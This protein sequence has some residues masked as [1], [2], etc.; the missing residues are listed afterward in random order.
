MPVVRVNNIDV[1]YVLERPAASDAELVVLVNGLAD[2]LQTWDY[3]VGDLL[4]AGYTVLRYDNRGIGLSSR[5]AGPYTSDLLATDLRALLLALDIRAFHLLGVSMG[6]MI[7][8]SYALKYPNTS[9]GTGTGGV[10]GEGEGETAAHPPRMLSLTLACTYAAPSPFCG[11]MFALWADVARAMGVATVMRDVL[12]WAFT[13][14]FFVERGADVAAFEQAMDALDMSV[15]AY[16][17]QL[18]IIR[19]FDSRATLAELRGRG[20]RL[21]GLAEG[22]TCVLVGEEDIL[23]PVL[24]SRELRELVVAEWRMVRGGHGCMWEFPEDF[25]RTY[26]RYLEGLGEGESDAPR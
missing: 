10:A 12:L 3:Q 5:P 25:N 21:G 8:Q 22:R 9:T 17:A 4:E 19:A 24:L 7:A 14:P 6:G 15:E 20:E 26:I 16:L 23:I 13:V 1:N 2:D 18:D 11:R